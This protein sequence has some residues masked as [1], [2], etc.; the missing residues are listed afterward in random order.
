MPVKTTQLIIMNFTLGLFSRAERQ[1]FFCYSDQACSVSIL[2]QL[3]DML[4]CVLK[5]K[6]KR[7]LLPLLFIK[8]YSWIPYLPDEAG[9]AL[10]SYL[11]YPACFYPTG[12]WEQSVIT[13]AHKLCYQELTQIIKLLCT[14][15]NYV[16]IHPKI[17]V[18][19]LHC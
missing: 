11:L 1:D 2:K 13:S 8:N 16:L 17:P 12:A 19:Q 4:G 5:G 15:Q 10:K 6:A 3:C 9:T 14:V 7:K 18:S